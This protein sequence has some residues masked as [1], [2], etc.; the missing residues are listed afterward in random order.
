[1]GNCKD[2]KHLDMDAFRT[3]EAK[4]FGVCGYMN[5]PYYGHYIE[6]KPGSHHLPKVTP[7]REAISQRLAT[8]YDGEYGIGDG[9]VLVKPEFG[10]LAFES[11][12]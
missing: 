11:K 8:S 10:C 3:T 1:M 9:I 7:H 4:G 5:F 6:D 2:C 12:E